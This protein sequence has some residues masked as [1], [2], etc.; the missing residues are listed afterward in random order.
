ML[1]LESKV[2]VADN[3]GIRT[4]KCLKFLNGFSNNSKGT[5][6]NI[7]VKYCRL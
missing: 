3:S 1:F 4:V 5:L 2:K 6:G 7:A